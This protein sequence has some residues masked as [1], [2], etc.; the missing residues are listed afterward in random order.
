MT[1]PEHAA[2]ARWFTSLYGSLFAI[3]AVIGIVLAAVGIY[4]VMAYS[5]SQRTQ[6]IGIRMALGAQQHAV[7]KLV[8]GQGLKLAA[9][10]VLI[11]LAGSFAI[12]RVM[13]KLLIGVQPTDPATFIAVALLLTTI[14]LLACYLPARRATRVDP[15][16]A[17]RSE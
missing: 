5:V 1:L 10:G 13:A 4:A 6:E 17:L 11:G 16:L 8:L 12:T 3:F 15:M 7:L 2:K 14:A 9:I